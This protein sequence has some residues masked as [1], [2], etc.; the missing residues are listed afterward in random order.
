MI[1]YCISHVVS[2]LFMKYK[3]KFYLKYD[4]HRYIESRFILREKY[5]SLT[6]LYLHVTR[7]NAA[8]KLFDKIKPPENYVSIHDFL[9]KVINL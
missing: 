5:S 4:I 2:I 8:P 7:I 3:L 1:H 9:N 6:L